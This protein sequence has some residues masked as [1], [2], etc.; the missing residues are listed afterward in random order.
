MRIIP[1]FMLGVM[2]VSGMAQAQDY[3]DK[4]RAIRLVVPVSVGSSVDLLA[5]AIGRGMADVAGLNV[6]VENKPGADGIIGVRAAKQAEPDG[7]TMLMTTNSTQV[8][9][10]HLYR[11]LPYDPVAD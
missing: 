1:F 8:V 4:S 3:P 7:Y 9:N 11:K 2:A 6:V 10:P 5:R